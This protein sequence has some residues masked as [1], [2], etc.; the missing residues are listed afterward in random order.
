MLKLFSILTMHADLALA[1]VDAADKA[2]INPHA[3]KAVRHLKTVLEEHKQGH[4]EAV[5]RHILEALRELELA[6]E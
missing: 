6:A 3:A 4:A 5:T 1:D 2:R